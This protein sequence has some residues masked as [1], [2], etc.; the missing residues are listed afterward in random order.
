MDE[1][2]KE[3]ELKIKDKL[4][5]LIGKIENLAEGIASLTELQK[6]AKMEAPV[7]PKQEVAR[8]L[9][10][11]ASVSEV[12]MTAPVPFE[13]R[14]LVDYVL[15]KSF[16]IEIVPRSDAPLFEFSI[17]VPVKYSNMTPTYK[18]TYKMDRRPKVMNYAEGANGVREWCEKVF[19]NFN[20]DTRALIVADRVNAQ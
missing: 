20:S 15:N 12:P 9:N 4:D 14:Q 19:N 17:V 13:Y 18:Q 5:I 10:V 8:T 11:T 16:G 3:K 6:T 2:S 7:E 1:K